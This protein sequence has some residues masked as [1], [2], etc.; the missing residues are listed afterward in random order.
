V[1][2]PPIGFVFKITQKDL[3]SSLMMA[4]YCRNMKEPVYR[5]KDWYK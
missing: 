3:R 4:G 5:I 2:T 1:I